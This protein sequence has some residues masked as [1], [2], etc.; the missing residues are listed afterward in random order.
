MTVE[1]KIVRKQQSAA[2]H[3]KILQNEQEDLGLRFKSL[4]SLKAID[5]AEAIEAIEVA[6]RQTTSTLLK[7]EICYCLGQGQNELGKQVLLRYLAHDKVDV[8]GQ[9]EALEALGCFVDSSLLPLLETYGNNESEI[10]V[11]TAY[12]AKKSI[13]TKLQKKVEY[14]YTSIDP[15]DA[16]ESKDLEEMEN[17]MLNEN[18]DFYHRYQAMFGIRNL[19]TAAS[20]LS[21]GK[22]F[23]DSS[24]LFRHE[25]AFVYGQ[26][27]D[28]LS[29]PFLKDRL[30]DVSE[31]YM[32]RHECAEALGSIATDECLQLL[33]KYSQDENIVVKES[34]LVGI[35]MYEYEHNNEFYAV[36]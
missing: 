25:I 8:M 33:K 36:A 17:I 2:E 1:F 9:H 20:V 35:D 21:L 28:P 26:L 30:E 22:G 32:V 24:T 12:L 11:Q 5:T 34:C 18:L 31:H 15:S 29:I 19:K 3:A 23:K 16:L 10:L 6:L 7:H 13:E 27:R 14:A 4:F